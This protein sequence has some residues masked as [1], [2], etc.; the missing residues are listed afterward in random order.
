MRDLTLV[1]MD[2]NSCSAWGQKS[3]VCY[4]AGYL[5]FALENTAVTTVPRLESSFIKTGGG[6]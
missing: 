4:W 6:S 5:N 1:L 3:L 2:L